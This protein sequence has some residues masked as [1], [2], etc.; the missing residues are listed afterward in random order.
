MQ[1]PV[2]ILKLV[3][4]CVF[5]IPG[6][7]ALIRRFQDHYGSFW[8]HTGLF[9]LSG[10]LSAGFAAGLTAWVAIP[11]LVIVA[12]TSHYVFWRYDNIGGIS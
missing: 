10:F 11:V 3:A 4:F 1:W 12:A 9:L 5:V 7:H 6:A 8:V 2:T